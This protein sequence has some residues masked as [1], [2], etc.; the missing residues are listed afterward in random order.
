[1]LA[2]VLEQIGSEAARGGALKV[3]VRLC[4]QPGRLA[5]G[6]PDRWEALAISYGRLEFVTNVAVGVGAAA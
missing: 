1:M 5:I 3:G 2:N 4:F 6:D